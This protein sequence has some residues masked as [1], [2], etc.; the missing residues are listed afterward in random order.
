MSIHSTIEE[1][2]VCHLYGCTLLPP[3][4]PHQSE[5]QPMRVAARDGVEAV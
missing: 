2:L 5:H 3:R 4:N 1:Y